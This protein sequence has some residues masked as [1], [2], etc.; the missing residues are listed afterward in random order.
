[1][2]SVGSVPQE[3]ASFLPQEGLISTFPAIRD[4]DTLAL[5]SPSE[6]FRR[7]SSSINVE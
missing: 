7:P 6:R 1:M 3:G 5:R 4:A 2:G